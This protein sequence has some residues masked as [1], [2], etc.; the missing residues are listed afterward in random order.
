MFGANLSLEHALLQLGH[1]PSVARHRRIHIE[2]KVCEQDVMTGFARNSL[3]TSQRK[4]ASS[5]SNCGSEVDNQSVESGRSK[6]ESMGLCGGG[7]G[8]SIPGN[9]KALKSRS[10][11][12]TAARDHVLALSRSLCQHQRVTKC[13]PDVYDRLHKEISEE[14]ERHCRL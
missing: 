14:L 4:A 1:L 12:A 13:R 7:T 6:V 8:V 2:Q 9:D 11:R 3:H 5:G 10:T